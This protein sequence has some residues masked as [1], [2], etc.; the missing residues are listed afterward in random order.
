MHW[1]PMGY[2]CYAYLFECLKLSFMIYCFPNS[3]Y[4]FKAKFGIGFYV[5]HLNGKMLSFI[6]ITLH[7][8]FQ[9]LF[10]NRSTL[11]YMSSTKEK[12]LSLY[13]GQ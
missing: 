5:L 1:E 9:F 10:L 7:L 3:F 13:H 4:I 2:L 12:K 11:V 6:M 8:F